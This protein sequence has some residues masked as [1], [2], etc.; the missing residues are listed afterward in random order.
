MFI[1]SVQ[2]TGI[3]KANRSPVAGRT[4]ANTCTQ[5]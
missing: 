2:T 3:T 5:V 4:A 1:A